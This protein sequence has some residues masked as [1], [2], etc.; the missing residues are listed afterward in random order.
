VDEVKGH[1]ILPLSR[2]I[3][4]KE[5]KKF[6]AILRCRKRAGRALFESDGRTCRTR[7]K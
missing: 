7:Q 6:Q 3:D 5:M 4:K 2:C 1:G